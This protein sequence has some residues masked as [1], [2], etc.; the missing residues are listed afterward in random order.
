MWTLVVLLILAAAAGVWWLGSRESP[1]LEVRPF[2]LESES[3]RLLRAAEASV[4]DLLQQVEGEAAR[5]M[6]EIEA[7]AARLHAEM[8]REAGLDADA[9]SH[10]PESPPPVVLGPRGGPSWMST[11]DW[12][13]RLVAYR[14]QRRSADEIVEIARHL[15]RR[16]P[17]PTRAQ[18]IEPAQNLGSVN[19]AEYLEAEEEAK[20]L[21]PGPDGLPNVWFERERDRLLVATPRGWINPKSR[22][23]ATRA[24][25]W[26]FG[27]RGTPYYEHAV[28]LG[29]FSPGAQVRLVREPENPHDH[30]AIAVYAGGAHDKAGHVPRGY[31]K[32]LAKLLDAGE[33]MVAISVRGCG[34]GRE[35]FV[36]HILVCERALFDHLTRDQ[37]PQST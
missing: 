18:R 27:V 33:D 22:T 15:E 17:P 5:L 13:R 2:D 12:Q 7:E 23:A 10:E 31:A 29:D 19:R 36:P 1:P 14:R 6:P 11:E 28:T 37:Q 8:M 25:L 4:P 16:G 35:D 9:S 21:E 24:G 30:N 34:V 20:A 32:R 26:S 3:A